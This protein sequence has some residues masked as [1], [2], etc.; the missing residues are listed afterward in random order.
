MKIR[1]IYGDK[2]KYNLFVNED[3][4]KIKKEISDLDVKLVYFNNEY[5]KFVKN[6]DNNLY[7]EKYNQNSTE[8]SLRDK[9]HGKNVKF[10]W[11]EG[12]EYKNTIPIL[13]ANIFISLKLKDNLFSN[14]KTLIENNNGKFLDDLH[15]TLGRYKLSYKDENQLRVFLENIIKNENDIKNDLIKFILNNR[16]NGFQILGKDVPYNLRQQIFDSSNIKKFNFNNVDKKCY[17]TKLISLGDM[18]NIF[19]YFNSNDPNLVLNFDQFYTEND[20]EEYYLHISIGQFENTGDA[21]LALNNILENNEN[22]LNIININLILNFELLPFLINNDNI[23]NII[24][25]SDLRYEITL[26]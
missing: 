8:I 25:Y 9:N 24:E 6:R 11:I 10:G 20:Y 16:K 13:F 21:F 5:K 4:E 14:Y 18:R 26:I 7:F 1:I 22:N 23:L 17:L 12:N 3:F 2:K 19:N 15:I